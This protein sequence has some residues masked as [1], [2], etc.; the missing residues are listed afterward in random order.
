MVRS[1]FWPCVVQHWSQTV[2]PHRL[3]LPCST[4]RFVWMHPLPLLPLLHVQSSYSKLSALGCVPLKKTCDSID[5]CHSSMCVTHVA[6]SFRL[7]RAE[8]TV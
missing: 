8:E 3:V 5:V 1:W 4:S 2:S 6:W 7:E